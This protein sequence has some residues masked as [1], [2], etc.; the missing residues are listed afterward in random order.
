MVKDGG[1]T[2][3]RFFSAA[4]G[5]IEQ[6]G[7]AR[8]HKVFR[9]TDEQRKDLTFAIP[10][11]INNLV[12]PYRYALEQMQ[13]A[14]VHF[15]S[16]EWDEAKMHYRKAITAFKALPGVNEEYRHY[17]LNHMAY[18]HF[19]L[20]EWREA[21]FCFF[22]KQPPSAPQV[23]PVQV[24]QLDLMNRI[25]KARR[26]TRQNESEYKPGSWGGHL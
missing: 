3:L 17:C 9:E 20:F 5:Q 21:I 8:P 10:G 26:G 1:P 11:R 25:N 16:E 24:E 15:F 2:L 23:D 6:R 4:L 14:D 22:E 19:R 13:K 12:D 18:S 7:L